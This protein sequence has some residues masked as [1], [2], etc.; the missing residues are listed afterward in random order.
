MIGVPGNNTDVLSRLENEFIPMELFVTEDQLNLSVK[1]RDTSF[2]VDEGVG[3]ILEFV[4]KLAEKAAEGTIRDCVITVPVYWTRAQRKS[5]MSAAE[6]A[7]LNVLSLIHENTAAAFYYGIDRLDNETDH[8]TLFYNM[9]ASDLEVSLAKYN[10]AIKKTGKVTNKTLENV[11]ILA[12][13]WDSSLGG[14]T[15]DALLA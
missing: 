10:A 6:A 9:G 8:Y 11:E 15:F 1:L 2:T 4:K 3:M 14:R 12:H 5:L 7:R 13:S